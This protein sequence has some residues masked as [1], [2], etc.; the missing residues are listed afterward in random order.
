MTSD[1]EVAAFY[2]HASCLHCGWRGTYL[3]LLRKADPEAW[4]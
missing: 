4:S 2:D 1:D 3:E